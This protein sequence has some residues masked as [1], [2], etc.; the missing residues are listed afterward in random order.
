M[1][2]EE[3]IFKNAHNELE[4]DKANILD[5]ELLSYH[6]FL[7]KKYKFKTDFDIPDMEDRGQYNADAQ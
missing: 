2:G 7:E 6:E 5:P 4:P 3:M 1:K